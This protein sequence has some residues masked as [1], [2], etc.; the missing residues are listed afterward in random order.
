MAAKEFDRDA[1][2]A[3]IEKGM[4][5]HGA[6]GDARWM[7]MTFFGHSFSVY[8]CV[9]C[10]SWSTDAVAAM[11]LNKFV[12]WQTPIGQFPAKKTNDK[13]HMI[14]IVVID[15]NDTISAD[16]CVSIFLPIPF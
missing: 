11:K 10:D 2:A 15:S 16:E 4:E 12:V 3:G 9:S 6:Y 13:L 14:W 7:E 8:F 1:Y 5:L